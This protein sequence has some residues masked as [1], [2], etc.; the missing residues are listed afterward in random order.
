MSRFGTREILVVSDDVRA[1]PGEGGLIGTDLG[2]AT[3]GRGEFDSAFK[4][5]GGRLG[6]FGKPAFNDG[7][8]F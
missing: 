1:E 8:E 6:T 4:A 5:F 2:T 3:N 7:S